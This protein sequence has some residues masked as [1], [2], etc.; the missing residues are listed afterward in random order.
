MNK[1]NKNQGYQ[2]A[3]VPNDRKFIRILKQ[4]LQ[5]KSFVVKKLG[6]T[7]YNKN[8]G[9]QYTNSTH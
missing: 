1:Y 4:I 2:Y 6:V 9:Y 8:Q 5:G 7:K 3:I